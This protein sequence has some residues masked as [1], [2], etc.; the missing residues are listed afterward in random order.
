MTALLRAAPSVV[1]TAGAWTVVYWKASA[2]GLCQMTAMDM[3]IANIE[4]LMAYVV[5]YDGPRRTKGLRGQF[6][7]ARDGNLG[8]ERRK[9]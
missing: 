3:A 8:Q 1:L 6:E 7:S 9:K 2:P 4:C 5:E